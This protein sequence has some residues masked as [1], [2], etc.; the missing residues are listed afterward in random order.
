MINNDLNPIF[1]P[2]NLDTNTIGNYHP[3]ELFR[4]IKVFDAPPYSLLID[5]NKVNEINLSPPD[6]KLFWMD[7]G[8]KEK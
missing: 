7:F 3:K 8:V 2:Y 5:K 4:I 6:N 1:V